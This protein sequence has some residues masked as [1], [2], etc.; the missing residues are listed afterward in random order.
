MHLTVTLEIKLIM[1]TFFYVIMDKIRAHDCATASDVSAAAPTTRR[2]ELNATNAE[3]TEQSLAIIEALQ[4][5]S[6]LNSN[7]QSCYL[8]TTVTKTTNV[9]LNSSLISLDLRLHFSDLGPPDTNNNATDNNATLATL[10]SSSMLQL[11]SDAAKQATR[12]DVKADTN[13]SPGNVVNTTRSRTTTAKVERDKDVGESN[14]GETE[15]LRKLSV[16]ENLRS[17]TK[18]R[19]RK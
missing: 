1:A 5:L 4:K 8:L 17:R 7:T 19:L 6:I 10:C 15:T 14:E 3:T 2:Y 13:D 12:D 11:L 18:V 16:T 9:L